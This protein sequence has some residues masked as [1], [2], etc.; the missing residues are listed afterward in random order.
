MLI[1]WNVESVFFSLNMAPLLVPVLLEK[2]YF[3][4]FIPTLK[5]DILNPRFE[6]IFTRGTN[7]ICH[8]HPAK[9][10][11]PRKTKSCSFPY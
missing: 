5:G 11:S 6:L 2:L 8:W 9:M 1:T 7:C 10:L 3:H 4:S